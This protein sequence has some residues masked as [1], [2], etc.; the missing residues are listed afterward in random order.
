M[1]V[2]R[3][4]CC[5]INVCFF[6]KKIIQMSSSSSSSSET[7]S[8]SESS[9]SPYVERKRAIKVAS[10][11]EDDIPPEV[12]EDYDSDDDDSDVYEVEEILRHKVVGKKKMYFIKWKGYPH[13]ENTWEEEK[14]LSCPQKLIEYQKRLEKLENATHQTSKAIKIPR[15]VLLA[16]RNN[17]GIKYTV[18]Y[19]DNSISEVD[20][21]M[22]K[23]LNPLA[24]IEYLESL[25]EFSDED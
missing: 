13:S 5:N 6:L 9:S 10:S 11:T 15:E 19:P 3:K 25:A 21:S 18:K 14:N 12:D 24:A 4:I 8:L 1:F 7:S 20:S 16:K 23:K 17:N 2:Y 22:M